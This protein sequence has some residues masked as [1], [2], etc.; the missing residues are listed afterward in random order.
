MTPMQ[1]P[2]APLSDPLAGLRDWHLP[3]PVSWW[4][5]A[6]GWWLLALLALAV[7]FALTRSW[8]RR[9]RATAP[10]R[11]A[12]AE[13]AE[14]RARLGAD[15]ESRAFV[16]AV[17][18]LLRRLALV[19]YPREQVAALSGRDWL[20]FLEGSGQGVVFTAEAGRLL[21]D[22][23]YRAR[24]AGESE[25]AALARAASA[26]IRAQGTRAQGIRVQGA[27]RPSSDRLGGS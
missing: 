22:G 27:S 7:G 18:R 15:L 17:S 25:L 16:A 24:P 26:W 1:T 4:P 20:A 5:P 9:R 19:R 10:V 14:L 13:L 21:A 23:P 3:D 8:L 11:A 6:P 2:G 12:L